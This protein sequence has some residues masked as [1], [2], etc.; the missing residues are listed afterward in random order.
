MGIIGVQEKTKIEGTEDILP[1]GI[2]TEIEYVIMPDTTNVTVD[3][4]DTVPQSGLV[5]AFD[6]PQYASTNHNVDKYTT[7]SDY[8][9]Q[10]ATE[11]Q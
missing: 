3:G 11:N 1:F 6:N 7:A 8:A 9:E 5:T 2:S 10:V 4:V